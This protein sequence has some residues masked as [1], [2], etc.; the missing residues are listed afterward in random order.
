MSREAEFVFYRGELDRYTTKLHLIG[1]EIRALRERR[2]PISDETIEYALYTYIWDDSRSEEEE[3]RDDVEAALSPYRESGMYPI[4]L[5]DTWAVLSTAGSPGTTDNESVACRNIQH[6]LNKIADLTRGYEPLDHD[7]KQHEDV[8]FKGLRDQE[9]DWLVKRIRKEAETALEKLRDIDT[10]LQ[11]L[12]GQRMYLN[13]VLKGDEE[14]PEELVRHPHLEGVKTSPFVFNQWWLTLAT[15]DEF[16]ANG[17]LEHV[18]T[19]RQLSTPEDGQPT[20]LTH[21][22]SHLSNRLDIEYE[23]VDESEPVV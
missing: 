14:A 5:P 1:Q 7:A 9:I 11:Y 19:M 12:M 16:L 10:T 18:H 21:F 15:G 6:E 22:G 2:I 23:G 20:S 8:Y 13:M 4:T 17:I 3:Q